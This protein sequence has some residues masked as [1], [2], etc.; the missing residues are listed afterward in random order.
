MWV[1]HARHQA[2]RRTDGVVRG[3]ESTRRHRSSHY[4]GRVSFTCARKELNI[5]GEVTRIM[6]GLLPRPPRP[7]SPLK[8]PAA[9]AAADRLSSVR[10]PL[11]DAECWWWWAAY[12]AAA[13]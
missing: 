10:P 2:L 4:G 11:S 13:A 5:C 8:R 3:L 12:A 6:P 1:H 7:L 9:E